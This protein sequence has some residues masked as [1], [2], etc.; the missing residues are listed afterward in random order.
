M[1]SVSMAD[2]FVS[3]V[4][5]DDTSHS[6]ATTSGFHARVDSSMTPRQCNPHSE[7]RAPMAAY[8]T[9]PLK[10]DGA[11]KPAGAP[12]RPPAQPSQRVNRRLAT[13][14]DF[15][16]TFDSGT[17]TP[18]S[19]PACGYSRVHPCQPDSV[20]GADGMVHIHDEDA[21]PPM[22]PRRR[23]STARSTTNF[24]AVSTRKSTVGSPAA[25]GRS[26]CTS[27]SAAQRPQR[28]HRDGTPSSDD[29]PATELKPLSA[30]RH[31][32]FDGSNGNRSAAPGTAPSITPQASACEDAVDDGSSSST[33]PSSPPSLSLQELAESL[34][35]T[36]ISSSPES[37]GTSPTAS[38]SEHQRPYVVCTDAQRVSG[39]MVTSD[40]DAVLQALENQSHPDGTGG[41]RMASC[42]R[43]S[44]RPVLISPLDGCGITGDAAVDR[45]RA[46]A[47]ARLSPSRQFLAPL[48]ADASS[49]NH[50]PSRH[51]QLCQRRAA[52][53]GGARP[54]YEGYLTK[55][56]TFRRNWKRRWCILDENGVI[57][58]YKPNEY[59]P[60][61]VIVP[62]RLSVGESAIIDSHPRSAGTRTTV[63]S[64]EGNSVGDH[65]ARD[66]GACAD[67][68]VVVV[69]AGTRLASSPPNVV[70]RGEAA[71]GMTRWPTSAVNGDP[72]RLLAVP[73]I[74]GWYFYMYA[75]SVAESE[76]WGNLID[77]IM[78]T[79]S[80]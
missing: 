12:L 52:K 1:F 14:A 5:S 4:M 35:C 45:A 30:R 8:L 61:G 54:I 74:G 19:T 3:N 15:D 70:V 58:Y 78:K 48:L 56:G 53:E 69:G 76:R 51:F 27:K 49:I 11:L 65:A 29:V 38:C 18:P 17:D 28:H 67:M 75:D 42:S 47:A 46:E 68:S 16:S 62:R 10:W 77:A 21:T 41:G 73:T 79:T 40:V 2:D 64:R 43:V 31:L 24:V 55:Q 50:G 39:T 6:D 57:R 71:L 63:P 36:D 25:G 32:H 9:D 34:S 66:T 37:L 26:G 13:A 72:S 60:R 20:A 59:V 33:S 7:E 80:S 23:R 44:S 22:A